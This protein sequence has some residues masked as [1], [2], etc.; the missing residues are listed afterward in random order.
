MISGISTPNIITQKYLTQN[1]INPQKLKTISF[2]SAEADSEVEV[3]D[4]QKQK[5]NT[6]L[7]LLGIAVAILMAV[8]I[9]KHKKPT[10]VVNDIKNNLPDVEQDPW[11]MIPTVENCKSLNKK[12][13]KIIEQRMNLEKAGEDILAEVGE[14]SKSSQHMILWGSSGVGKSYFAK[15]YAKSIGAEYDEI[16]YSEVNSKWAGEEVEKLE[17][18]LGYFF[19]RAK[20]NPDKNY[21]LVINEMDA[22][23][24][25]PDN[26][27]QSIG[28]HWVSVLRERS[29]LLNYMEKI[30]NETPNVTIIG[31]TNILPKNNDHAAISRMLPIKVD[32][33]EADCL[34]EALI[35]KI[36]TFTNGEQIVKDNEKQLRKI[37]QEMYEKKFS[38]RDLNKVHESAKQMHIDARVNGG[39]GYF[40]VDYLEECLKNYEFTDGELALIA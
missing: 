27:S 21:I 11:D 2:K 14:S 15:V 36:K 5:R 3:S 31:T 40:K 26:L 34:Y 18:K 38:Y 30:Q 23:I 35:A 29:T 19:S 28:T 20:T 4:A 39:K 1:R 24:V 8:L 32:M 17:K 37:T 6:M 10:E 12:L 7:A 13:K 22:F 9:K 16:L 33:P 25:P